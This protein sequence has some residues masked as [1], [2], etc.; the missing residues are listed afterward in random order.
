MK[1]TFFAAALIGLISRSQA[2]SL[3]G[4][5][6]D[7]ADYE[8]AEEGTDLAQIY[9]DDADFEEYDLAE[10]YGETEEE[11]EFAEVSSDVEDDSDEYEFAQTDSLGDSEEC[12][13]CK[14]ANKDGCGD[15]VTLSVQAPKCEC[16]EEKKEPFEQA[17]LKALNELGNKST[18]LATALDMQFKKNAKLAASNTMAVSGSISI[19]PSK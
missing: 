15:A 14:M 1:T 12:D 13:K 17:M 16:K 9:T 4:V 6:F 19:E 8:L 2:V 18:Q 11:D 3:E 7:L 5:E 10:V